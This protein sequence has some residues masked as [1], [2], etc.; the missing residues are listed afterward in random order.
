MGTI[1]E[2]FLAALEMTIS[3]EVRDF[4]GD[5]ESVLDAIIQEVGI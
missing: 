1:E 3:N 2:R 4:S 5:S